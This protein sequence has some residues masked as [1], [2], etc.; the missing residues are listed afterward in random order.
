[1][2]DTYQAGEWQAFAAYKRLEADSVLDSFTDSDFYLGGTN[3]KG[4][5]VGASYGIDKNAWLTARWFS[6]DEIS[7]RSTTIGGTPLSPLSVD[8]LMLDLN[9]KF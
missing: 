4:W 6:A 1:M 9:T 7:P 2:R 8:V 3:A 5:L